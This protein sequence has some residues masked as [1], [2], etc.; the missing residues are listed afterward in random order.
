[1]GSRCTRTG[2]GA[3]RL[4]GENIVEV[5]FRPADVGQGVP[6]DGSITAVKLATGAVTS[7]KIA[8][9]AVTAAKLAD[10]FVKGAAADTTANK[11]ILAI[12][13]DLVTGEVVVDHEA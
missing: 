13:Y 2:L 7:A 12:G 6:A 4:G 3:G 10:T 5:R 1:M 9:A 11:G 8:A